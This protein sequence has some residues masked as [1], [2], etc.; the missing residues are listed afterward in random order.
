MSASASATTTPTG[1]ARA[2]SAPPATRPLDAIPLVPGMGRFGHDAEFFGTRIPLLLRIAA[3]R[4]DLA[5]MRIF[6]QHVVMMTSPRAVHEVLVE[7][8]RHFE[9][10]PML[11]LALY[12]LAGEGL[13]TSGGDL[14]RQQRR[15]MAP[16]FQPAH[17]GRYADCMRDCTLRA[18]SRYADGEVIDVAREMT[19]ITMSIIGKALFDSDT[20]EEA[21][22]VGGALTH[23]LSWTTF[24]TSS[25]PV[26]AQAMLLSYATL[27]GPSLPAPLA[28]VAAWLRPRLKSP[29]LL[30]GERS[31]QLRQALAILDGRIQRMIDERRAADAAGAPPRRDLLTS[32]LSAR[33]TEGDGV[34]MSDRQVRDEA[35]TLF[36]AGHETT[37]VSL[38]WV[39]Y[40]LSRHAGPRQRLVDEVAR[41]GRQPLRFEDHARLPYALQVFKE[42]LRMYPPVYVFGRQAQDEV[43]V[44]DYRV[45]QGTVVFACPY[46]LHHRED[47]WP[48]PHRFD[49]DRFLP[50]AEAARPRHAWLPFSSGP[51]VC[52]G[53]P[54]ALL[55]AQ[56]ILG[57][58]LQ[59]VSL[60]P[61]GN[62]PPEVAP[63]PTAT[64]RPGAPI[65]M[66]VRHLS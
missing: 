7:K 25:L 52:I 35:T 41:L 9:K 6:R 23:A 36:V 22:E 46:A 66:R 39:A 31:R 26:A 21:D 5:R 8:S 60:E 2:P 29:V 65:L 47:L 50:E 19:R 62:P 54:F 11:Q 48:D 30:P 58:L 34:P 24:A 37:A 57:T 64:L 63:L 10:S 27:R 13:F 53:Q 61:V 59:N 40:L 28:E 20:F 3:M 4:G 18:I 56:L 43:T 1:N 45:P 49:P 17:I 44:A 14:W 42:A 51:R 55:E 12:P 33:D 16:L 32:L 38:S 15:L